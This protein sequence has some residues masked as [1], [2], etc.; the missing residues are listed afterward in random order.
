MGRRL[1]LA[2]PKFQNTNYNVKF[3]FQGDSGGPLIFPRDDGVRL[4]GVTSFTH[5]DGCETNNPGGFHRVQL[6]L[7]FI[8][9]MLNKSQ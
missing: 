8:R 2:P 1:V 7:S 6:S 4:V 9:E 5:A 3:S